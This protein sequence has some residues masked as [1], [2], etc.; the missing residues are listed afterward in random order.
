MSVIGTQLISKHLSVSELCFSAA[1]MD[2]SALIVE[3]RKTGNQS[4]IARYNQ[5]GWLA[6]RG[7]LDCNLMSPTRTVL[8]ASR[9][10]ATKLLSWA[11]SVGAAAIIL[12]AG[13]CTNPNVDRERLLVSSLRSISKSSSSGSKML[14]ENG[15]N[16][17]L[18]SLNAIRKAI[19][20]SDDDRFGIHLNVTRAFAY[21]YELKDILNM[22]KSYVESVQISLPTNKVTPGCGRVEITSLEHCVW[23]PEQIEAI[24]K[25][26]GD[27][28]II[29]DST[30][31]HDWALVDSN[32]WSGIATLRNDNLATSDSEN[33]GLG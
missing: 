14:I 17:S 12:D 25:Y 1:G 23:G 29:I 32:A 31:K 19:E 26:Y 13:F 30:N 28:P 24:V 18:G 4:V 10:Y 5:T 3:A 2:A 8:L 20:L 27:V 22:D 15:P 16:P 33:N 9:A 7:H 21:G 6:M 11:D